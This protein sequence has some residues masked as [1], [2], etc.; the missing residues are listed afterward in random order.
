MPRGSWLSYLRVQAGAEIPAGLRL[1]VGAV[2]GAALSL[3]YTGLYLSIYSWLCIGILLFS[4]FG[5]RARVA[6]GCGFLHG[7]LFVLTSVPWI[8]TVLA[9]HG[10]LSVAGGWGLLL[11]I[12]ITW[13]ILTGAFA[14]TVHR[15]SLQS[16]E[17][18]CIGAPFIWVTFEFVRAHLPEISFPWNLLG[19]PAAANL[20]LVQLTTIT[21]IYGLSFLVACFNALLAWTSSSGT[22][23]PRGR[24]ACA[25][26]ATAILLG[27]TLAG[28]RLVPQAQAHHFA[29]AVQLNFPEVDSY[30]ADWFP[31]HAEDLEEIE[32]M[33]LAPAAEKPDLLVWPEAPA[34]F[35]FQDSQFAKIASTLA[36]RFGHPFLAGAIEWKSPVNAS[37]T[38]PQGSLL[39]YNSALLFDAQGR[40][41]F[42]YDKFHL[43]PFGEYEPFPLIHRVVTSVSGEVGSFHKGIASVSL[44]AMKRSIRAKCAG[45]PPAVRSYSSTFRMTDGL[46]GP[47]PQSSI[48]AW[49]GCAPWKT[50][51]GSCAPRIMALR[52]RSI[53]TAASSSRSPR[54]CAP[55]SIFLMIFELT[56]RFT[57]ALGMGSPGSVCSFPLF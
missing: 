50:A 2:S 44:S 13:G 57:R 35:S 8:A 30:A 45:L 4:L 40:R 33:S 52:F 27:G 46:E 20:G 38:A 9:V 31:A 56:K 54:M 10:G 16:I 55:R 19:Y 5:A 42:V 21:G 43:V 53:P 39:P 29:R 34:P 37:D 51:A 12:A 47:P 23:T 28:P 26:I 6:S 17:L 7:L 24:M 15:V 41:T 48:C 14:W 36:I 1:I 18:A 32:R 22:L 11:L 3:S 25:A 49:R